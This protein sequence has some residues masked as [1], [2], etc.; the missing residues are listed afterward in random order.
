MVS[1]GQTLAE[2]NLVRLVPV[3]ASAKF[4]VHGKIRTKKQRQQKEKGP[5]F[6]T[7]FRGVWLR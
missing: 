3:Q 2:D 4:Q 1:Q 5:G 7:G 6:K